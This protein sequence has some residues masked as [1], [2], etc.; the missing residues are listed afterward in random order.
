M[1][2][3]IVEYGILGV[4][5]IACIAYMFGKARRKLRGFGAAGCGGGCGCGRADVADVTPAGPACGRPMTG[6]PTASGEPTAG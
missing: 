5:L 4:V 1:G 6:A 3:Q 2:E